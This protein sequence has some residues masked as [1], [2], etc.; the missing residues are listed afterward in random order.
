[1]Q[2]TYQLKTKLKAAD[3]SAVLNQFTDESTTS[4]KP[5]NGW[6]NAQSFELAPSHSGMFSLSSTGSIQQGAD[7]STV[8]INLS[9]SKRTK[10]LFSF[11]ACLILGALII[12]APGLFFARDIY[13]SAWS[14]LFLVL[15]PSA[16]WGIAYFR[17][18]SKLKQKQESFVRTMCSWLNADLQKPEGA[19]SA[20]IVLQRPA[21]KREPR[22]IFHALSIALHLVPLIAGAGLAGSLNSWLQDIAWKNWTDG[23]YAE[24]EKYCRP[25][26]QISEWFYA[27]DKKQLSYAYYI[28]AECLRCQEKD[29]EAAQYYQKALGLQQQVYRPNDPTLA[30]TY[31]N[32]GRSLASLGNPD[33]DLKYGSAINIWKKNA[34]MNQPLIARSLNRVALI[35][36]KTHREDQMETAIDEQEEVLAIDRE[37]ANG[38]VPGDFD[39]TCAQD[40]NDLA[41]IYLTDNKLEKA[42]ESLEEAIKIKQS[43]RNGVLEGELRLAISY[44]NLADVYSASGE[45]LLANTYRNKAHKI[46]ST[47]IPSLKNTG[48]RE[49]IAKEVEHALRKYYEYPNVYNRMDILSA[50]V[51][52]NKD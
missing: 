9:M 1:M 46:F 44:S 43:H 7:G 12:L 24:A 51:H 25:I 10:A 16:I 11:S 35:H 17:T 28:F 2:K 23:N 29:V 20:P 5:L 33:A 14:F 50:R 45:L 6:V 27:H 52:S 13:S 38:T 22:K 49:T 18:R 26:A 30:W 15:L 4:T 31:D 3:C 37:M 34:E 47:W 41:V 42:K 21:T 36:A 40:L 48:D 19:V 39:R 32:L 8:L